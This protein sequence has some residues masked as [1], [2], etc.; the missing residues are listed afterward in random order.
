MTIPLLDHL[1]VEIER[2]FDHGS[3]SVYNG[4]VIIPSKMLTGEK[5]LVYLL[6]FSKMISHVAKHWKK[7]WTCGKHID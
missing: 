6:V 1:R 4:L 3:N 5:D 7:N 2:R